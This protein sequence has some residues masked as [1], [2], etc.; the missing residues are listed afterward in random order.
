[1]RKRILVLGMLAVCIPA[2]ADIQAYTMPGTAVSGNQAWTGTLG[3]DF[4]VNQEIKVT[5][6]GVFVNAGTNVPQIPLTVELFSLPS[7]NAV[8]GGGPIAFAQDSLPG[9]LSQSTWLFQTV[10]SPIFLLPGDYTIAA[11]GYG[12]AEENGNTGFH[13][14]PASGL[15][16]GGGLITF[17][18]SSRYGDPGST[19]F[20]TI[21]DGSPANRYYAGNFQFVGVPEPS[22]Y[23]LAVTSLLAFAALARRFAK[24]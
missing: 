15:N 20:P 11:W 5:E 6:L 21:I 22:F 18:G 12:A 9:T 14:I 16:D 4:Q 10:A 7:G 17:I 19:G 1:M 2:F 8:S 13:N 24:P 23:A 3:M